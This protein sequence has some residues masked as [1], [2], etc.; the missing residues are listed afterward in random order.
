MVMDAKFWSP[1]PK[2]YEI[3]GVEKRQRVSISPF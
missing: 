1:Q 3:F 2:P